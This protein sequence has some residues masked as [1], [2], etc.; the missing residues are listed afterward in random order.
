MQMN[1]WIWE[2][3]MLRDAPGDRQAA[4]TALAEAASAVDDPVSEAVLEV[5]RGRKSIDQVLPG[6][7]APG[8]TD[9]EITCFFSYWAAIR[10]LIDDRPAE[11]ET[12]FRRC[13]QTKALNQPEYD[14]AA[15][16]LEQLAVE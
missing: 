14:L 5:C 3:R 8:A 6:L 16:H 7:T 15:W 13:R 2:L 12:F 1:I 10:A 9:D 11:A 4:T